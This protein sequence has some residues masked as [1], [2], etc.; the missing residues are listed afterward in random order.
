MNSSCDG[1]GGA[2]ATYCERRTRAQRR[3][4]FLKYLRLAYLRLALEARPMLRLPFQREV[5]YVVVLYVVAAS[6]RGAAARSLVA[7][8]DVVLL[9][10]AASSHRPVRASKL[11]RAASTRWRR[12]WR[13]YT[14]AKASA[15]QDGELRQALL[16]VRKTLAFLVSYRPL[17]FLAP[18]HW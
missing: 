7:A 11:Q 15:R 8:G 10:C 5:S 3:A 9:Q 18:R 1:G 12:C 13:P 14:R 17:A 16:A 2:G 4:L 6:R